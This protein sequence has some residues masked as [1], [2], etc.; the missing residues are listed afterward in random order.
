M[1]VVYIQK[2]PDGFTTDMYDAVNVRMDAQAEPPEGLICHTLGQADDGSWR[3][4]DVWESREAADRFR[5]DRLLP[6][7]RAIM[8][9][10]GVDPDDMPEIET[11]SYDAYD[12]IVGAGARTT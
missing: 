1:A 4:I 7:I 11:M 6:A 9:D 8:A 10:A 12:L 5:D 3:I 2:Q